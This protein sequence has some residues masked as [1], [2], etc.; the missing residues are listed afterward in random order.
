MVLV[1]AKYIELQLYRQFIEA[2][3]VNTHKCF[4]FL[5]TFQSQLENLSNRHLYVSFVSSLHYMC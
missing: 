1:M 3:K 4:S 2:P 5:D